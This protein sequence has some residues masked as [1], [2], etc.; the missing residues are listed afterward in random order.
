MRLSSSFS[1][2][3][4]PTKCASD[5]VLTASW[6]A[7]EPAYWILLPNF[8]SWSTWSTKDDL[9]LISPTFILYLC[10]CLLKKFQKTTKFWGVIWQGKGGWKRLI[11]CPYPCSYP[12]EWPL[13][14]WTRTKRPHMHTSFYALGWQ[15]KMRILRQSAAAAQWEGMTRACKNVDDGWKGVFLVCQPIGGRERQP[16]ASLARRTHAYVCLLGSWW[17]DGWF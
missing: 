3:S 6:H 1:S 16:A 10:H 17:R 12:M 11:R 2:S 13:A 5:L 7:H 9:P 14:D 4:R 8:G 15:G